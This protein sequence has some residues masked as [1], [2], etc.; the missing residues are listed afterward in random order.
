MLLVI[1]YDDHGGFYDHVP[2]PGTARG[3]QRTFA[4]L[5]PD[6][7]TYLGVRVPA[8]VVSPYVS[9]HAKNRTIFDH[10][11]I[12]KTILV[13]N[14]DKLSDSVLSG[15]GGRVNEAADLSA[16]L[17]NVE[18]RRSPQPF[19]RR[20]SGRTPPR[21]G[22]SVDLSTLLDLTAS[23]EV[24]MTEMTPASGITPREMTISERTVPPGHNF[25]PDDF[26]GAL[27]KLM[28]PRKL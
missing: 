7:P 25:E 13:H 2:P 17:D 10:T 3:E 12:L 19:I 26:H 1:T 15:F 5:H 23:V 4:K 6:G 20:G 24:P 9:S 14:R 22:E 18:A 28:R 8:F 27:Y 16:V 21:F 11:S